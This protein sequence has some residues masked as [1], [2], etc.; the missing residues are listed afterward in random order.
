MENA[1]GTK[2]LANLAEFRIG[3]C[4]TFEIIWDQGGKS[5]ES[6][7]HLF[8]QCLLCPHGTASSVL[9]P[10]GAFP[11]LTIPQ[12]YEFSTK[13]ILIPFFRELWFSEIE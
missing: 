12:M 4:L 3:K 1:A 2:S 6:F 13:I 9:S 11:Y 5:E 8:H 10:L 7:V